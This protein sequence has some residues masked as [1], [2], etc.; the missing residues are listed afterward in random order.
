MLDGYCS[1]YII[2]GGCYVII[3]YVRYILEFID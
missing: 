3:E 2:V 1:S